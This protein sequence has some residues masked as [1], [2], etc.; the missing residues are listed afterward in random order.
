MQTRLTIL[1]ENSVGVPFDVLGEHGFA[2]FIETPE[3]NYLFDTGQGYTIAGNALALDKDLRSIRAIMI[4]HGHYD[5]T[6]GLPDVLRLCGSID[7]YAHED[8]FLDRYSVKNDECREVGIRFKKRYLE[9]LGAGFVFV[10]EFTPIFDN[11]YLS[12]EI[13]RV[14]PFESV[15]PHMKVRDAQGNLVQDV[16]RDD[17]TMIIDSQEGLVVILGCAH[18]G[19]IN[20][21]T[22]ITNNLPNR[23]IHM[24]IG[25]THLGFA[26]PQQ[27]A[28]TMKA[29]D[30]F[31]VQHLGAGHCTGLA[32]AA[33]LFQHFGEKYFFPAVGTRWSC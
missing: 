2:C 6:S 18:S 24:V 19:L 20:I 28:Q 33:R 7:V 10:K 14:T 16:L 30:R 21:L 12:G 17:Q 13:P 27:F 15:D 8:C 9:S 3:G 23:P 31:K 4:S 11:I 22:H 29:L 1:C 32:N 5:H 25:G 26:E